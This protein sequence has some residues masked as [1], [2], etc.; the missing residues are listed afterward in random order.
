MLSRFLERFAVRFASVLQALHE[1]GLLTEQEQRSLWWA[2]S[3]PTI[4]G[5]DR[6]PEALA[7]KARALS[8]KP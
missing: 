5:L 4:H 2:L 6:L 3:V 7:Q 1:R 8:V